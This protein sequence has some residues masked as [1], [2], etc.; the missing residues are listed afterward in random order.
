MSPLSLANRRNVQPSDYLRELRRSGLPRHDRDKPSGS[1]GSDVSEE[2]AHI[3]FL[4]YGHDAVQMATLRCAEL[5]EAGDKAG[6]G[7]LKKGA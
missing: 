4:T 2:T 7:I 6:L 1:L 5:K 3:L